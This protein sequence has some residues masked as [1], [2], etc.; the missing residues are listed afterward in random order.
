MYGS[1]SEIDRA[2]CKCHVTCVVGPK[3]AG[4]TEL[5][6]FESV[7]MANYKT[8][9]KYISFD[10]ALAKLESLSDKYYDPD[11]HNSVGACLTL[12]SV[13]SCY[14]IEDVLAK[15]CNSIVV[16]DNL[17]E[18]LKFT[19]TPEPELFKTLKYTALQQNVGIVVLSRTE[20][21][22]DL[23]GANGVTGL[24]VGMQLHSDT[25]VGCSSGQF[26]S[27]ISVL[28][29]RD[30]AMGSVFTIPLMPLT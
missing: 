29:G 3:G 17:E 27:T 8:R 4:K 23:T 14:A 21:D 28:K 7:K 6:L 12:S 15:E 30:T 20:K 25:I 24:P 1:L 10:T 13:F 19:R 9:V 22:F 5:A 18:I 16:L 11:K 26:S 2:F